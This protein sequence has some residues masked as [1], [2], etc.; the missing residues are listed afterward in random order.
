MRWGLFS[1]EDIDRN[2]LRVTAITKEAGTPLPLTSPMQKNSFSSRIKKSYRSPPTSRAGTSVAAMS[3]SF[4]SGKG[5][6]VLGIMD[7]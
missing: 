6:K 2:R 1:W 4:R 3:M 5:G 7:I